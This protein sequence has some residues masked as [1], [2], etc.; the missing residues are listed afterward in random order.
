[1]KW[2]R[3]RYGGR[4]GGTSL[5][6]VNP[7]HRLPIQPTPDRGRI[8]IGFSEIEETRGSGPISH[9]TRRPIGPTLRIPANQIRPI[10]M[11]FPT[12]LL[13]APALLAFALPSCEKAETT[14][15]K[16]GEKVDDALDRRPAEKLQDAAEDA[17]DA[18]K[19]AAEDVKDAVNDATE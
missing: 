12:A 18:V 1:M 2:F 10:T 9:V 6:R 13:L 11:K 16:V 15:E 4:S 17:G 8:R 3:R 19:D 5:P 7:W 14:S